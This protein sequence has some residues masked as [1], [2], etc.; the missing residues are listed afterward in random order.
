[1]LMCV[2]SLIDSTNLPM[3]N[4]RG[5]NLGVVNDMLAKAIKERNLRVIARTIDML[6]AQGMRY[7]EV[8]QLAC[9]A[10]NI[11]EREWETL[12]YE[13]DTQDDDELRI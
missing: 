5:L 1:M 11:D 10:G 13:A 6:R 12:C 4:P 3:N 7:A 2:S 9:K 8:A